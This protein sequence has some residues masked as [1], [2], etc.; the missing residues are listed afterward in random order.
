MQ[1]FDQLKSPILC[2]AF[3]PDGATLVATPGHRRTLGCWTFPEGEFSQLHPSVNGRLS[4]HAYSPEGTILAVGSMDG[5][6]R[7][8]IFGEKNDDLEFYPGDPHGQQIPVYQMAFAPHRL[9]N[10]VLATASLGMKLYSVSGRI[11]ADDG[12]FTALA[13]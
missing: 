6:V 11:L 8:Y 7:L 2:L 4:C 9:K 1:L 5:V 13:W 12:F 10:P 3:S